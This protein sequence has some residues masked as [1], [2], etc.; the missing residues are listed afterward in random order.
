VFY[1]TLKNIMFWKLDLF[2]SSG[3]KVRDI[4]KILSYHLPGQDISRETCYGKLSRD[5]HT[6]QDDTI[7]FSLLMQGAAS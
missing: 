7:I 2:L 5:W 6:R 3:E 4:Y 1:R